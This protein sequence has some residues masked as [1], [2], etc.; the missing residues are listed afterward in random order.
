LLIYINSIWISLNT[1]LIIIN[2]ISFS[3][4]SYVAIWC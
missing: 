3:I 1:I 4:S 2:L